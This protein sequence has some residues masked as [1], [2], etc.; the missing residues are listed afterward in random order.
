MSG[1]GENK[2][3]VAAFDFDGTLTRRETLLP[4]LLHTLGAARVARAALMLAPTLAGYGLRLIRNDLAKQQVFV[5]CL[6]GMRMDELRRQGERF[7]ALRLPGLMREEAMQRLAWHKRQGHRC[8]VISASL[9]L[10]IRPWAIRAGFDDVLATH[11][12]T[13]ADGTTT[14]RLAGDNCYGI[15]KVK[16]L[17]ALLGARDGYTLYAYGD[18][19]GDKELL[20]GADHA[21]YRYFPN[22][23]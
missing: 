21:Y 2:P 10:Y 12:E 6:G 16:R 15:E 20:S 3:V 11:L 23:L 17:E 19:R 18:S 22:Q 8:V 5:R 7:A 9:D 13:R 14:G 1:T 4:F